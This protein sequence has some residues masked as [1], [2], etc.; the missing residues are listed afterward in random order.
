MQLKYLVIAISLALAGCVDL[1]P[2]QHK[3]S[4]PATEKKVLDRTL[5]DDAWNTPALLEEGRASVV[6]LTPFSIPDSVRDSKV[7]IK[8]DPGAT[9]QD[10]VAILGELGYSIILADPAV[11]AKQ[12]YL[13]AYSGKLG[14]LLSAITRATDVW[15]TWSDDA[16]LVSN[17]ERI[18]ISVPQEENFGDQ[19]SKGLDAMGIK[20][21]SVHWQAGMASIEVTPSQFRRLRTY[22]ERL[23]ANAA[24]VTLQVA[25]VNVTLNQSARQGIDWQ[26]LQVSALHGG[27]AQDLSAWK[28]ANNQATT[29]TTNTGTNTGTTTGTTTTGTA[30]TGTTADTTAA[31]APILKTIASVGLLSGGAG[32]A[33][34]TAFFGSRFSV[35]GLFDFL[36]S[37]GDAETKQNVI[38]KTIAGNKVEFKSLIQV[39]Y[40]SEISTT[41]NNNNNNNNNNTTNNNTSGTTNTGTT[42]TNT[43]T[44][45]TTNNGVNNNNNNNNNLSSN[46]N[47]PTASVKTDKADDGIAVEMTPTFDAAANSVTIALKLSIKAVLGFNDISAG[48]QIGRLT[49]PTTAERSFTD[50]LRMRP[51]QT[52]IVG[53][54]T[55]DNVSNSR[56]GPI[57]TQNTRL[58]SQALTV[59]R[60]TMF[61]VVRPTVMKLGSALVAESG[62][63]G[64]DFLP[65]G[66]AA[67]IVLPQIKKAGIEMPLID[68]TLPTTALPE[69]LRRPFP[70]APKPYPV[71]NPIIK[72]R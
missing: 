51:G 68:E 52:A 69:T 61:I 55:Y 7:S 12:F 53:G 26:K 9:I 47:G 33:L 67:P 48:N 23:T 25:V 5:E 13:P 59:S 18:G 22:L 6:L 42:S 54:L 49:Q 24:V 4:L 56:G 2:L 50:T 8:L 31:V 35:T 64:L 11:G 1:A 21:K 16:L 14:G 28:T 45:N 46:A 30:T 65:K 43:N 32:N 34:Q 39:P 60:T 15:F 3:A 70:N 37:Y 10:V 41:G 17:T 63:E 57:F 71:L 72:G 40:V 38:L 36:Q 29:G 58:D 27:T 19:L 20:E 66:I 62:G 44:N